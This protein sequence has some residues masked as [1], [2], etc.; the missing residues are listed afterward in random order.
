MMLYEAVKGSQA[1]LT[2]C[3][4]VMSSQVGLGQFCYR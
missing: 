3:R 2:K 1:R 4:L